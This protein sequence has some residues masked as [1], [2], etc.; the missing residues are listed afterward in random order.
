M[1]SLK[2]ELDIKCPNVMITITKLVNGEWGMGIGIV[3]KDRKFKPTTSRKSHEQMERE[4]KTTTK[5]SQS[6][7]QDHIGGGDIEPSPVSVRT[8]KTMV[9]HVVTNN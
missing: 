8:S 3:S 1:L 2:L 7:S 9:G 4:K 6:R 5:S